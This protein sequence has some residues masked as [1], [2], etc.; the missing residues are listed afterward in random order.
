MSAAANP[1]ML[2]TAGELGATYVVVHARGTPAD[3]QCHTDYDD[4]VAEVYEFLAQG[5]RRC[6][7]AG[8]PPDRVVVDPG[9][10]FAKTSTQNLDLLRALGQLR[11]LGHPVLV[12]TSR[13]RFLGH[14]S[15]GCRRA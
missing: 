13:K 8:I 5:V 12:G 10:G 2:E 4:V 9:I 14:L 1:A 15:A 6:G 7:V 11:G 3:M